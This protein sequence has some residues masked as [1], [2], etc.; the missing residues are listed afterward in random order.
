MLVIPANTHLDR[1]RLLNRIYYSGYHLIDLVRIKQPTCT[2]ITFCYLRHRASHVNV[3]D[4][5]IRFLVH[6]LGCFYEGITIS[7]KNLKA[8]RFLTLIYKQHLPCTLVAMD[9]GFATHHLR[10]YEACSEFFCD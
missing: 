6:N 8:Q 3:D 10:T 1:Y 7:S 5:C 4:V 9:N 2:C